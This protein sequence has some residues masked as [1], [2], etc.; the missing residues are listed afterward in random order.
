MNIKKNRFIGFKIE[1]DLFNEFEKVRISR[2]PML[3]KTEVIK[4]LMRF[5]IDFDERHLLEL[6]F[7]RKKEKK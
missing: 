6:G 4:A 5:Y 2:K 1:E 3:Q 7:L